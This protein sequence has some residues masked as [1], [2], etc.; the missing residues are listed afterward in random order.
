M[1]PAIP[2]ELMPH[3]FAAI[4]ED[5][6]PAESPEERIRLL[7]LHFIRGWQQTLLGK[8]AATFLK[9]LGPHRTLARLDRAFRTSDNYTHSSATMVGPKE[10]LLT[11]SDV[12]GLPTYWVGLLSGGLEFLGLKGTVTLE[13][14]PG[15]A[16]IYRL[17]WE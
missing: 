8:A 16:A 13:S 15:P 17:R 7:G 1:P 10:V 2:A 3:I 5:I 9:I 4:A 6:W 14:Y 12:D 11:I